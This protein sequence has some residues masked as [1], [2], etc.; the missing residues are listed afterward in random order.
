VAPATAAATPPPLSTP[1]PSL[2]DTLG[3]SPG[4]MFQKAKGDY[5]AGQYTLAITGFQQLI[6]SYGDSE[7]AIDA[8]YWIGESQ[9]YLNRPADAIAAFNQALQKGPRSPNA[10]AAL[11]KRGVAQER[12]GDLAGARASY[13]QVI[14]QFPSNDYTTLAQQRLM[15]LAPAAGAA[16]ARP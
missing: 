14:K 1:G 3:Q 4:R 12:Q 11:Y 9:L 16:P 15:K 5:D 10:P 13:E 7:A 8:Y 6:A 2:P